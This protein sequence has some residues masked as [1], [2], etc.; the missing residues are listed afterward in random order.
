MMDVSN[1][2]RRLR[3]RMDH[4]HASVNNITKVQHLKYK[5]DIKV[6]HHHGSG[7]FVFWDQQYVD[8]IGI[9]ASE[10]RNQMVA[11]GED[12]PKAYPLPLDMLLAR[13]MTLR[14]KVQPSYNQCF[15]IRLSEN[16][17]LIN[18]ID[19][20]FGLLELHTGST[21]EELKG[22]CHVNDIFQ[23]EYSVS[24]TTDHDLDSL[25]VL[26]PAKRMSTDLGLDLPESP[27][28]KA[29][30]LSSSKVAKHIK[31]E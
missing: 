11:E 20:Q 15:V 5:L 4:S 23:Y 12:D 25:Q 1:V 9:S 29:T 19:G 8:I 17:T 3:L 28:Y 21:S 13:T 27:L 6:V 7:R 10:L 14:V 24:I 16:P 22:K 2:L 30:Q 18:S 31:I 26:T